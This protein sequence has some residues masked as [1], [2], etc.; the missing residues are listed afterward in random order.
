MQSHH[1]S[2]SK[3]AQGSDYTM[4]TRSKDILLPTWKISDVLVKATIHRT[5]TVSIMIG[6][7]L[8]PISLDINGLI[9]LTNALSVVEERISRLVEGPHNVYGFA[10]ICD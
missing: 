4:N 2:I 7:S 8:N 5:D 1:R 9:R 6:C 3:N 10:V